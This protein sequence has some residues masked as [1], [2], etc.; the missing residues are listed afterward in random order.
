MQ[1]R[2]HGSDRNLENLGNFTVFQ[3]LVIRQDQGLPKSI[4]QASNAVPNPLLPLGFLKF[5]QRPE[6]TR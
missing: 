3:I 6:S 5:R 2:L 4:G 1:A